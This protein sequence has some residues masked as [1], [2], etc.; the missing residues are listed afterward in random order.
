MAV[1]GFSVKFISLYP[2]IPSFLDR[3]KKHDKDNRYLQNAKEHKKT[4]ID[5]L[6]QLKE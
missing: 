5:R 6:T 2:S 4:K 3:V 1:F